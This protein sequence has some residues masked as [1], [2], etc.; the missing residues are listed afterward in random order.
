MSDSIPALG[1]GDMCKKYSAYGIADA[2]DAW[3]FCLSVCVDSKSA[4]VEKIL[5]SLCKKPFRIRA[6]SR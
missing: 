4:S 6:A 2:V 3:T 5:K 1:G